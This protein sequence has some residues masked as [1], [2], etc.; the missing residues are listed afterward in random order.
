ML[1][2]LIYDE[3]L[4]QAAYLIGCQKTG[5]AIVIDPQRDVDQYT[6]LAAQH[7]LRIVAAAETHI[8]A[9]FLSGVRQFAEQG[10]TAYVSGEGGEDWNPRWLYKKQGGGGAGSYKHRLLRDGDTFTIGKIELRAIHTPGHTPEHLSYAVTDRGAGATEPIGLATGDFIFVGDLGRPDLL[11][12]AAGHAGATDPAARALAAAARKFLVLPDHL[13]VWPGHGAGS[14]CGKALGAVP[15]TT[16]GYERRTSPALKLAG[17][18]RAFVDFILE[19]QPDPPRYFARMKR[20]NR[21][22]PPLL[23]AIP[24]PGELA[25]TDLR[26]GAGAG[27]APVI[28]D[29]RP[30]PA[31]RAGH[32]RGSLWAPLRPTFPGIVGSYIEETRPIALVGEPGEIDRAVRCCVRIGL[33]N[34]RSWT[35]AAAIDA[36]G[37]E[38]ALEAIREVSAAEAE[39][40]R[41]RGAPVLDVRSAAEHGAGAIPGAI[42]IPH[43]RLT[44]RLA[45]IPRGEIIVHC[46]GGTRSAHAASLL[47][48]RGF[49]PLNLAG[50]YDAWSALG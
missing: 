33:D 8:H 40:L 45:E 38:G 42:N 29:M 18:E 17:D 2:R 21:D 36:L 10:V 15:Q 50:G 44:E 11:E 28:V 9:D 27:D 16:V 12:T 49:T 47:A 35:P 48:A 4:A 1:L 26:A 24:A 37:R 7:G 30:W 25:P 22:G 34:A 46:R 31:F 32:I 14:A 20:Q 19:G 5:E 39:S 23:E 6:S 43:T 41:A 13:Q 3:I